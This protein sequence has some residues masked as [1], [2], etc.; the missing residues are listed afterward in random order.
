VFSSLKGHISNYLFI[1][2]FSMK[3]YLFFITSALLLFLIDISPGWA[4]G[5]L[6]PLIWKRDEQGLTYERVCKPGKLVVMSYSNYFLLINLKDGSTIYQ[7]N[8]S[9]DIGVDFNYFGDKY[10]ISDKNGITIKEYDVKTNEF[11]KIVKGKVKSFDSSFATFNYSANALKFKNS[12][13]GE[14]LDSFKI[15][16]TPNQPYLGT[17]AEAW[18]FT[19]DGKYFAFALQLNDNPYTKKFY[20]YDRVKREIIF[21]KNVDPYYSYYRYA[22]FNTSNKMVYAEEIQLPGDDTVYSYIRIFDPDQR[23]VVKNI[24]ITKVMQSGPTD[25]IK[26]TGFIISKDD[27]Y[28]IHDKA[29]NWLYIYNLESDKK[30][31]YSFGVHGGG[32]LIADSTTIYSYGDGVYA[33]SIDW[34]VGVTDK[35]GT[36][37][38]QTLF[39]N[40]T[41]GSI[42]VTINPKLLNGNWLIN[43]LT[44]AQIKQGLIGNLSVL[45]LNLSD[46]PANT[47]ILTLLKGKERESYK[48]I[49]K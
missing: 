21:N 25:I 40:P 28:I 35:S 3:K 41:T 26:V 45:K 14:L 11:I 47:Y 34:T 12:N 19:N 15:P 7:T 31:D 20:L 1:K 16:G 32:L 29:Q 8:P 2:E 38:E 10:Y 36:Q 37:T 22:F 30:S 27:K 6:L 48:I 5:E 17:S 46:L 4:D 44:G 13:T 42:S 9:T 49:K 18:E 23:K 39:P 33:Q 24:K 43:N